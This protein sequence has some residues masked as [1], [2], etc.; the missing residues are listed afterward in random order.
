M[1]PDVH[2]ATGALPFNDLNQQ[3]QLA[4]LCRPV[5]WRIVSW[6]KATTGD[7]EQ[8]Y[9]AVLGAI[10]L[11]QLAGTL[12][13]YPANVDALQIPIGRYGL[14]YERTSNGKGYRIWNEFANEGGAP[15]VILERDGTGRL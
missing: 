9:E 8:L 13:L 15:S 7:V 10:R 1:R 4:F 3:T 14:R 6:R 5:S 11:E 2:D 12:R